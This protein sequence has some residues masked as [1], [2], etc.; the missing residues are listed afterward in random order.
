MKVLL[1]GANGQL[2]KQLQYS[3]P[4]HVEL[5]ALTRENLD[6]TDAHQVQRII[7]ELKP[8]CIINA[9]AYNAVDLAE[10]E[11]ELAYAVNATGP[12]NLAQA[13]Y[14]QG[15]RLI[16]V[17]TD[18]VFDGKKT[19]PYLPIDSPNPLS[20]YGKTKL[21][22]ENLVLEELPEAVLILRTS[23]VYSS[24]GKNFVNNLLQWLRQK[25]E[26]KII[27]DQISAP[28]WTKNLATAICSALERPD[29]TGIYHCTDNDIANKYEFAVTVQNEAFKLGLLSK[30]IP[31]VAA[32]SSD[33][34]TLALRPSY[35]VLDTTK[36]KKDFGITLL[37]WQ[38]ALLQMLKE[39][40]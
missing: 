8:H 7:Y 33:F 40:L 4:E 29:L 38:D 32:K 11:T 6:I 9:A 3:A 13:A 5:V 27:V 18:Y 36:T 31:I 25:S 37:P 24:Y 1:T 26:L 14:I 21:A 22:G 19:S 30:K 16:H 35:S 39:L 34:S 28:T 15:A 10:K 23:W 12:F 2:A 17:S 20:W